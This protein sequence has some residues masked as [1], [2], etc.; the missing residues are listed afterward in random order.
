MLPKTHLIL[1]LVFSLI[2]LK[3]F[4]PIGFLGFFTIWLASFLIDI[5]HYAFYSF[6][7]KDFN[8]KHASKW[9]YEKN[10]YYLSLPRKERKKAITAPCLFHGIE[11]I[12]VLLILAYFFNLFLFI[13]LGFLFHEI[14]DLINITRYGFNYNHILSQTYNILNF[15]KKHYSD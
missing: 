3:L 4:P 5:D 6:Y 11:I 13:L 15:R 14:L 7:K 9:F 12:I 10:K 1:G 8:P 2:I